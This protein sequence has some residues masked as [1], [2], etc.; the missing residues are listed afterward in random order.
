MESSL[1]YA[2]YDKAS[3]GSVLFCHKNSSTLQTE[4]QAHKSE[5]IQLLEDL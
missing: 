2:Q 1:Q 4:Q 3:G 5:M